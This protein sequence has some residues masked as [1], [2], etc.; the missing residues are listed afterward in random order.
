MEL[1]KC[2]FTILGLANMHD[3]YA[4]HGTSTAVERAKSASNG[5]KLG[6]SPMMSAAFEKDLCMRI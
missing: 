3:N 1:L 6:G 5:S 2:Q 4:S